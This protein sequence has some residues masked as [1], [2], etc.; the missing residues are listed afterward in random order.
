MTKIKVFLSK[1]N[2]YYS[3]LNKAGVTYVSQKD[4][5]VFKTCWNVYGLTLNEKYIFDEMS[6]PNE[7]SIILQ[8]DLDSPK[9]II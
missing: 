4:D 8:S 7:I 9:I 3:Y 6:C 1:Y 2:T 5:F